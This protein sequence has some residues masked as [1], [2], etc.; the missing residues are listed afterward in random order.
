MPDPEDEAL[1]ADA[2]G[3]ALRYLAALDDRPVA[4]PAAAIAALR[5]ALAAPLP[6][7]PSRP[8]EVLDFVDRLGS[9][10][11]VASAGRRY[12]G[13]VTGGALPVTV[14]TAWLAAAWDQ[15][16]FSMTSSPAIAL[17]EDAALR[18][19]AEAL[20][21][22]DARAGAI[23]TGAT[24]ANLTCLAAARHHVL[25][26]LGW[27]VEAQGLAGA[28]P[29]TVIAGEEAHSS[30]RKVVG[31]LGLG[32]DRM[33]LV[34]ADDQGR[35]RAEAV[36]DITGPTILCLQAGN[37]NSGAFDPAE[38]I[39]AHARAA[40]AWVHVDGAFGLWAAA[41]P[42]LAPLMA[43]FEAADS[44]ATDAHKQLNVP[45]DSG[46]AL[47]RHPEALKAAM[48][49][50]AAYLPPSADRDAIDW[51]PDSSRR[52]RA[53]EVWVALKAFG[54][55]GLAELVERCVGHAQR[56]AAALAAGG[57]EV[58]NHVVFNQ[59]VVAFGDDA[60]TRRVIEAVQQSGTCWCGGTVW[61]GRTA[62]R[63]SFSS[64]ATT[65]EDVDASMAAI[66]AAFR[67]RASR[68]S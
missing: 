61:R 29:L 38:A 2:A 37:V 22:P 28:P 40:G 18:W 62:M 11:T 10:A 23:V 20:R 35:M 16:S 4:A 42:R 58:L 67:Q 64:W 34:P 63:I 41:S 27:D 46:A 8:A 47:V 49:L 12:F 26:Q 48:S 52:A 36:P 56:A 68:S 6:D 44:W 66:L 55:T 51:T 60:T 54:R 53:L 32:R 65:D 3:R 31:I 9:P 7:A 19:L 50:A 45:Y 43:G 39:I 57:V 21:L 59:V 13:F 1:L 17:F 14:A 15:N 30:L 25:A 5:E 24:M 33:V